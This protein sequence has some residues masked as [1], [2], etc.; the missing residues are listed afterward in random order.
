M[1]GSVS[2]DELSS[3]F[4]FLSFV[5]FLG[6]TRARRM[7]F[8]LAVGASLLVGM[9][10]NDACTCHLCQMPT[11]YKC[12]TAQSYT[13]MPVQLQMILELFLVSNAAFISVE[14]LLA[15]FVYELG[16]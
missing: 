3:A 7:L 15:L 1:H 10:F 2:F 6:D 8:Q 13:A 11:A 4:V 9:V 14:L 12:T 16:V 5:S